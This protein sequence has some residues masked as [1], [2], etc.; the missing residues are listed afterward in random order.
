MMHLYS[1]GRADQLAARLAETLAEPPLD[2]ME[3]EWV[4]VSSQGMRRWLLL[5]LARHLGAASPEAGDGVA[6]NFDL[7]LPGSL[8]VEVLGAGRPEEDLDP[9]SIDRLVWSLL[10][11]S[12]SHQSDPA[13]TA[14]NQ[15]PDGASRYGKA[16]RVAD[17]FDR[18]HVHRPH[19][20]QQWAAGHDVGGLGR[21]IPPHHAWQPH[22]WRLVWAHIGAPSPPERWPGLLND[23]RSGRLALELPERITLFG[24]TSLPGGRSLLELCQALAVERDVHLYL[25]EPT[26]FDGGRLAA[27]PVPELEGQRIR[28]E[29]TSD[30][31]A[32]HP[33]LRSWGRPH[34]EASI[35]LSD[36][37]G[38]E[39]SAIEMMERPASPVATTLLARLQEDIATNRAPGGS[40]DWVPS[41][42]SLHIH[43]CHGATRQV[44]VLRDAILHLLAEP[45][46]GLLEEDIVVICPALDRFAP[47]VE[48]VFGP[49]ADTG[50]ATSVGAL[51]SPLLRYRIADRSL[52]EVNP[53][54]SAMA[55]LIELVSGR[56]D[57][58]SVLDF[59]S[60]APVRHRFGFDDDD[61]AT[62][63]DWV[64]RAQVRWGLT[65]DHRLRFG[66]PASIVT[67]TWQSALDRL[68]MGSAISDDLDGLA[69]GGVAVVGVEGGDTA[70]L[71]RLAELLWR[72]T[73]LATAFR[74]E[75]SITAWIA[76]LREQ[77][78]DLFDTPNALRWQS[79]ALSRALAEVES[80]ATAG[81]EPSPV[82]L[83]AIDIRR[84]FS[85]HLAAAEGRPDFFR[86]GITVT[87]LKPL[88]GIPFRV[89]CVLGADESAIGTGTTEGDDLAALVPLLGDPDQRTDDRQS[90]L[91]AVL[92]AQDALVVV[93][94]GHDVRT[95]QAIPRAVVLE[96]LRDAALATVSRDTRDALRQGLELHHPR[97]AFDERC[98]VTGELI[99]GVPWSFGEND[100]LG[101]QARRGR[102][103]DRRPFITAPLPEQQDL[104]IELADLHTFLRHPVTW[105]VSRRLQARL[106]EAEESRNTQLPV[107]P[108]ALE[109]WKL[110]DGLLSARRAGMS[111]QAWERIE[112]QRGTIPPASIGDALMVEVSTAVEQLLEATQ[113]LGVAQGPGTDV[114]ID[115]LLPGG[116]RLVGQVPTHLLPP[117]DGPVLITYSKSKATQQV[118]AWLDL[119]ALAATD[120]GRD[121][122][123]IVVTRTGQKNVPVRV[124]VALPR[125]GPA[126]VL[127]SALTALDVIVDC[128]RRGNVEPL[129]LFPSFSEKVHLHQAK[130]ADWQGD[131]AAS[132]RN[133][134]ATALVYGEY[135]FD[136][137][138]ALPAHDDDPAGSG[139]R[140][141]RF[142]DY[143]YGAMGASITFDGD[144]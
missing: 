20:V 103:D 73:A 69:I 12:R 37:L 115:L 112:R 14:F 142:A 19:M 95:N 87:T 123:S 6:A 42:P 33:L 130:P 127:A 36:A 72:L 27:L 119:M 77:A 131:Y 76:L 86:G 45:G 140:V 120:P 7:P 43:A 52:S 74:D 128:Y 21:P 100:R 59:I 35:L 61:L 93:R 34:R 26:H 144:P 139:G 67:N 55:S 1:A 99:T 78:S 62:I 137:L 133:N 101:A 94:E 44:E 98:F 118:A 132:E 66:L 92:A 49:S 47:L 41:D 80:N 96:E 28:S 124:D 135:E 114:P 110:G 22:L 85:D 116:V 105:F 84:M 68:L 75:H 50:A 57:A 38:Y 4:G 90:L 29:D 40:L 3:M 138:L 65:P 136:Q 11:V 8:R 63:V 17:L 126:G 54:L 5:E 30:E 9:W 108:N 2:P 109:K 53:V 32:A 102:S 79:Q 89:V 25:L 113:T 60:L 143:L 125:P 122:R 88:R 129:P 39:Y 51:G 121:W 13:L 82:P 91:E 10:T 81:G 106:H 107:A 15:L 64:D 23:L 58:T 141:Q 104:V 56:F 70:T 24:L 83:T 48:G 134:L 31:L 111:T 117:R 16:R 71:G 97:Q 46:L 18:Y